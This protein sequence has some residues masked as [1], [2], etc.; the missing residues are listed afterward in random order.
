MKRQQRKENKVSKHKLGFL[1]EI[2]THVAVFP[3]ANPAQSN[4]FTGRSSVDIDMET[5]RNT[6][7][8]G[9]FVS[10]TNS[11]KLDSL[12]KAVEGS[13]SIVNPMSR[14]DKLSRLVDE[15]SSTFRALGRKG[16][17]SEHR[18]DGDQET[19]LFSSIYR[20]RRSFVS[21]RERE[22]VEAVEEVRRSAPANES[23]RYSAFKEDPSK[24]IIQ[25][26]EHT[27]E[28][29]D[30]LWTDF[31]SR[32]ETNLLGKERDSDSS[33][34]I[35][36]K[37]R[38]EHAS[39]EAK[40]TSN[41]Y[42]SV[43]L[44]DSLREFTD[45]MDGF[46]WEQNERLKAEELELQARMDPRFYTLHTAHVNLT[47]EQIEETIASGA[48]INLPM[49]FYKFYEH[50]E[51]SSEYQEDAGK[52][53]VE[54][55]AE[56]NA[57]DSMT[58]KG[59]LFCEE[60]LFDQWRKPKSDEESRKKWNLQYNMTALHWAS[61]MGHI[62]CVRTLCQLGANVTMVDVRNRTAIEIAAYRQLV[63]PPNNFTTILSILK[64][65]LKKQ[66]GSD[67]PRWWP[68]L[69][70][71]GLKNWTMPETMEQAEKEYPEIVKL[72]NDLVASGTRDFDVGASLQDYVE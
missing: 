10:E 13:D 6:D 15:G 4:T 71:D 63:D 22:L 26:D 59:R 38:M 52:Y 40:M 36:K 58:K 37:L 72:A 35:L 67:W 32:L 29:L 17:Q 23:M 1:T 62:E 57:L 46:T 53:D 27:R 14:I 33:E 39:T 43:S 11:K 34:S 65:H 25:T 47:E 9:Y 41:T 24:P 45:N 16:S 42:N 54:L 44:A 5:V 20:S 61:M 48:D 8:A 28:D 19:S 18:N 51:E 69:C 64:E 30:E 70:D 31:Q 21:E 7:S 60:S 55:G 49:P 56:I 66:V 3:S 68:A 50:S 12:R 2:K